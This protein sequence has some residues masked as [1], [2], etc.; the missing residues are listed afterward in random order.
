[1]VMALVMASCASTPAPRRAAS[2]PAARW[3]DAI[4]SV[5]ELLA[6][7]RTKVLFRDPVYGTW[8]RRVVQVAA[9]KANQHG[10]AATLRMLDAVESSEELFVAR[11]GPRDDL[12]F[13]L[14]GV[15]ADLDPAALAGP[16]GAPLWTVSQRVPVRELTCEEAGKTASLFE[17]PGRTWMI[18]QGDLRDRARE[19]FA[20]PAG[21]PRFE[22]APGALAAVR[23]DGTALVRHVPQFGNGALAHVGRRL[24][25]LTV[26]LGPGKDGAL[27]GA[28]AYADQDAAAASE[29]VLTR[30]LE[31]AQTTEALRWLRGFVLDRKDPV[32]VTATA[33]MS[34]QHLTELLKGDWDLS[35]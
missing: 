2:G 32:V 5:P 27:T 35:P 29:A 25:S 13:V 14:R 33:H 19:A 31:A 11:L 4:D 34:A 17:L 15:R 10:G 12:V 16:D 22:I 20:H 9:T 30:V 7:F 21:R 23:F 3:E 24:V 26:S 1:M 18:A 8:A 6:E 28:F